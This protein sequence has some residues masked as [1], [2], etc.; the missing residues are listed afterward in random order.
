MK[1]VMLA[2]AATIISAPVLADEV[3]L[4]PSEFDHPYPGTVDVVNLPAGSVAM[5]CMNASGATVPNFAEACSWQ[6]IHLSQ[7]S[8]SGTCHII[9][10][11]EHDVGKNRLTKLIRHETAHCNGW[12]KN[13][14]DPH[15]AASN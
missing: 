4:P 8:V 6:E 2:I 15:Y 14:P 5:A 11:D 1:L 7:T 12:P 9:A 13:H 3:A 10:P